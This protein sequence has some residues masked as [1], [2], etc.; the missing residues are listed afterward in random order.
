MACM[1]VYFTNDSSKLKSANQRGIW[2][3]CLLFLETGVSVFCYGFYTLDETA[4]RREWDEVSF[5]LAG[6]FVDTTGFF[7]KISVYQNF[8]IRGEDDFA[9]SFTYEM[10]LQNSE[11]FCS[12]F[13]DLIAFWSSFVG[14][15][16]Y[17][18]L[19]SHKH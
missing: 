5:R 16:T 19:Y 7:R 15:I 9:Q 11:K 10:N 2:F 17:F 8:W 18:C 14:N 4:K 3:A 13:N 6:Y 12:Y 1:F